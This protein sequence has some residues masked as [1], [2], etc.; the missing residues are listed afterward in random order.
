[1]KIYHFENNFWTL[2]T[3]EF[4]DK[5]KLATMRR[6]CY[7]AAARRF[8]R[9]Q[10]NALKFTA[11][12]A[13]TAA[14][15]ATRPV[16]G[17]CAVLL[18]A[19]CGAKAPAEV[20]A[21][22]ADTAAP[23]D[24]AA[25][26]ADP[27]AQTSNEAGSCS[28]NACPDSQAAPDIAKDPNED[29][30]G[31]GADGCVD[32]PNQGS[33]GGAQPESDT[34]AVQPLDTVDVPDENVDGDG[35]PDS[36]PDG[37]AGDSDAAL[38][39]APTCPG[40]TECACEKDNECTSKAC[41]EFKDGSK[42]C[43][44]SCAKD[45]VCSPGLV[46][47][48]ISEINSQKPVCVEFDLILCDPC[49]AQADCQKPGYYD[50]VCAVQPDGN[51]KFCANNCKNN[52]DCSEGYLCQ[53]GIADTNGGKFGRCLPAAGSCAC[54]P[55]AAKLGLKTACGIGVCAG[56]RGCIL[57]DPK[58]PTSAVL[59][60]CDGAAATTET[61]NGVD[62][63]CNGVVDDLNTPCG[64]DNPCAQPVCAGVKGCTVVNDD[65]AP[66]EDGDICTEGDKCKGG[67][68]FPGKQAACDDFNVCTDPSCNSKG[69]CV[70][71]NN[72]A[73]CEDGSVC[74]I[75]DKCGGGSCLPGAP[76][77]CNDENPCTNDGCNGKTGC[78]ATPNVLPC[79]DGDKCTFA[80]ACKNA[81][82][83]PGVITDCNDNNV[84]TTGSCDSKIGCTQT[85]NDLPCEDGSKCTTAD[86]CAN[87]ACGPGAATNCDDNNVCTDDACSPKIGCGH[88]ANVVPCEDGNK[89]T[90]GD[91]CGG[92]ICLSGAATDCNDANICTND[93]CQANTGCDNTA[94]VLPCEDGSKC[95]LA[96]NCKDSVC[97]PGVVTDCSDNNVCTDDSCT[98]KLGCA[99][100]ANILLCDDGNKCTLGDFC[101]NSL[102]LPDEITGCSD[103]NVCTDDSC[104]SKKGCS[105]IANILPCEDGSKCTLGDKCKDNVC[106]PGEITLCNDGNGCTNDSC[107]KAGGCQNLANSLPCEDGNVCTLS[108]NCANAA[109]VAGALN[110]CDDKNPCTDDSCD[111]V[112]NCAHKNN[113]ALCDDGQGCTINDT[114]LAAKCAGVAKVCDDGNPCTTDK[115]DGGTCLVPAVEGCTL[116]FNEVFPMAPV[117][118]GATKS[119]S[120]TAVAWSL[121]PSLIKSAPFALYSSWV[122]DNSL[123]TAVA[124]WSTPALTAPGETK[125]EFWLDA[126]LSDPLCGS[127]DFE[128]RVG[129]AVLLQVC[130]STVGPTKFSVVI[131][132]NVAAQNLEFR[133]VANLAVGHNG[134]ISIDNIAL[135]GGCS[136]NA[137]AACGL[138][139][140]C[141]AGTGV[142]EYH[143]VFSEIATQGANGAN[144]EFVEL[145]NAGDSAATLTGLL[146]QYR[147]SSNNTTWTNKI[148]GGMPT[149]TIAAHGFY[150]IASKSYL[151]DVVA[152]LLLSVD[153]QVSAAAATLQLI[154]PVALT[155]LDLVGY[156]DTLTFE[157]K[158]GPTASALATGSIE[159]KANGNSTDKTM[160][161]GGLDE[162]AG[163]GLDGDNNL[164]DFILRVARNPQNKASG[165]EP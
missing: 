104:D 2:G 88:V 83:L 38:D 73:A 103:N 77:Q 24:T 134:K 35:S 152:D 58:Q 15:H 22:V 40:A 143:V 124:T 91:K 10:G 155:P 133:A 60:A 131:P 44:A 13:H 71:T 121:Q 50:F 51:G 87:S 68:C 33:D 127:D 161:I 119:D 23:E 147:A 110:A 136:P 49:A 12:F 80:D 20:E 141:N 76:T 116:C 7:A 19:A 57:S 66:C 108:D 138:G 98:A 63:N 32:V 26:V 69:G 99:H 90:I 31:C 9:K 37:G 101:S 113:V 8:G 11:I 125:L 34:D 46:C 54:T 74:T 146:L 145:Y 105:N 59:S 14:K 4:A 158:Q 29:T 82:C 148:A 56:K 100:V 112:T 75:G 159:R 128:V 36:A 65:T 129:N 154:G 115:C 163:N 96:D 85:G 42:K 47:K 117:F 102:C 72:S 81:L 139:A 109:C 95:T 130:K 140:S 28:G 144:D 64:N 142:C 94:N 1:M 30:G 149:A 126:Q 118:A 107:D 123:P 21:D 160:V 39:A 151:G 111:P 18:F 5:D 16:I 164:T 70:Q 132:G 78:T 153:M 55:R 86:K 43:A 67:T 156:G 150:L 61:C 135:G 122:G 84:C 162:K 17:V 93:N 165:S 92:S 53:Q 97:M 25:V 106:L 79:E 114:C 157:S 41:F 6:L 27:D 45:G 120:A 3:R 52:G 62:D 137:C 89:C 48:D